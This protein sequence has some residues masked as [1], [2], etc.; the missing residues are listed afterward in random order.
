VSM[1]NVDLDLWLFQLSD[2]V[3][4]PLSPSKDFCLIP[5][6]N[7]I[8]GASSV[9]TVSAGL[10]AAFDKATIVRIERVV[11]CIDK[12]SGSKHTTD[13]DANPISIPG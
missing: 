2:Q 5:P 7:M 6:L 3:T 11:Y 13:N 8:V 4:P 1:A 9:S 12:S 10:V